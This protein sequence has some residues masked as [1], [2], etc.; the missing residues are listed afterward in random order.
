MSG[1][2][3]KT[4]VMH[5]KWLYNLYHIFWLKYLSLN[6]EFFFLW[7]NKYIYYYIFIFSKENNEEI[8]NYINYIMLIIKIIYSLKHFKRK[9]IFFSYSTG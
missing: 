6:F 2:I 5:T 9:Y 4:C 3:Y 7:V 8:K 1:N